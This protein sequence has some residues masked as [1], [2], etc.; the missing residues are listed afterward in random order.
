[1]QI[2][3][4]C[5]QCDAKLHVEDSLVGGEVRC[6]KCEY[7][8]QVQQETAESEA[9]E[10]TSA[11]RVESTTNGTTEEE[12]AWHLRI[13]EGRVYGPVDKKILDQWVTEGRVSHDCEVRHDGSTEDD[14]HSAVITYP[15]LREEGN[16]FRTRRS[17]GVPQRLKP[18]RGPLIFALAIAGCLVPFL[19]IW[20]AILG[21][22]DLRQMNLG[23]MDA[24]GDVLTRAGQ[25][26]AM[27]SS[28]IWVG[29][30]GIAMLA[31]LIHFFG[32][33]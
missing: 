12:H 17:T 15:M 9:S 23:R 19:S 30:F 26:V 29:A 3:I 10:Q 8:I 5:G 21:T 32:T 25:A 18:H 11:D 24:S 6:P 7:V 28:M 2:Q 22:R 14:W 20:P 4:H 16:P 13:P 33:P 31:L 27:V 1:M